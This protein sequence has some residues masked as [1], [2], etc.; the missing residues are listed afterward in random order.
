MLMNRKRAVLIKSLLATLLG[1]VA[2]AIMMLII[3]ANP[4]EGYFY[5]FKGGVMSVERIS[6]VMASG[7]ALVL[8][9]LSVAFAFQTGLFNIGAAG[10]MLAGGVCATTVG[11]LVP[12]PRFVLLPLMFL[13]ALLGGGL[14]GAL[15]GFLKAKFNVHE[16]VSTIMMNWIAYWITF[17]YIPANL[18]G[19]YLETE[20]ASLPAMAS[21][22]VPWLSQITGGS[23]LN[24]GIVIAIAM[25]I[26]IKFILDKTT[27]GYELKA[28]GQN[29][30]AALYA[31]IKVNQNVV[32]SMVISGG[33]A[34]LAGLVYY[35]G[36]ASSIQIGVL[37]PQG[38]DGIAVAL[39]GA[40]S[41]WGV[42]AA[43]MFFG[44]LHSAKGF[45]NAVTGI[46]PQISDTIIAIII[47]F[48]ATSLFI[49]RLIRRV[50][51]KRKEKQKGKDAKEGEE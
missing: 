47:Y 1:L 41:P 45:M 51:A 13:A 15:P 2:G 11:L 36:Y 9:G 49:E 8:T 44:L 32:L 18:K 34:G 7:T 25:V 17:Y 27:L 38:F 40:T 33:L 22:R 35:T 24:M 10:Q 39:L 20:S 37:P 3:G 6:N 14:W 42:F 48:T 43:A 16:V 4:L 28:V 21:L 46:P 12:A 29:R 26:L 5:L 19:E 23:Y 31:G 50:V 30:D